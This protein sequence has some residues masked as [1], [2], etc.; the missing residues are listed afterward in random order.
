MQS[1][2]LA[3]PTRERASLGHSRFS[4]QL[5]SLTAPRAGFDSPEMTPAERISWLDAFLLL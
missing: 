4:E 2:P 5:L 3:H 1:S